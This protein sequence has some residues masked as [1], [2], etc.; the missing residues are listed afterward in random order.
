MCR[1]FHRLALGHIHGLAS[2]KT[3]ET[4]QPGPCEKKTKNFFG[5]GTRCHMRR[6]LLQSAGWV[7]RMRGSDKVGAPA[8]FSLVEAGTRAP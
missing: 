4:S 8:T 7:W 1:L 3:T 5:D 2:R 6:Y